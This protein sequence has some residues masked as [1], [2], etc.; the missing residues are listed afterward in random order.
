MLGGRVV[1]TGVLMRDVCHINNAKNNRVFWT[2]NPPFK[3]KKPPGDY[4]QKIVGKNGQVL[5]SWELLVLNV[6]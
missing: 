3:Y 5:I 4:L 6:F 2:Y 1:R